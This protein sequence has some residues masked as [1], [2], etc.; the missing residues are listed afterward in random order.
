MLKKLLILFVFLGLGLGTWQVASAQTGGLREF[1]NSLTAQVFGTSNTSARAVNEA[2][3]VNSATLPQVQANSET[4]VLVPGFGNCPGGATM[5]AGTKGQTIYCDG[6]RWVAASNL[7]NDGVSVGLPRLAL[8]GNSPLCIDSFGRI[9]RGSTANGCAGNTQASVNVYTAISPSSP[10]ARIVSTSQTT[11]TPNVTLAVYRLKADASATVN[12]LNIKLDNCSGSFN[13]V[14]GYPSCGFLSNFRLT[15][16]SGT[17]YSG[18][19]DSLAT[20]VTFTN[21]SLG[22]T[23]NQWRD[24]TLVA[25]VVAL[26]P[27]LTATA[28]PTLRGS[29]ITGVDSNFRSLN[30]SQ[31]MDVTAGMV[32]FQSSGGSLGISSASAS[33]GTCNPI[34]VNGPNVMCQVAFNYTLV[35]Q[36]NSVVYVSKSPTTGL[37]TSATPTGNASLISILNASNPADDSSDTN[38]SFAIQAGTAR[39]FSAV[40]TIAQGTGGSGTYTLKITGI[41]FGSSSAANTSSTLTSGL[42][43]LQAT[44]SF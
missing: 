1:F 30:S 11:T 28:A 15:D 41:K 24:V 42:S 25:D 43:N 23:A 18:S 35:N 7:V 14:D 29:S 6:T 16:G 19:L 20:T 36:G 5:P 4:G 37:V 31:A 21:L 2:L 40:G 26:P 8:G 27:T 9:F 32:T 3:L 10:A 13:T 17:N 39:S 38:S 22:L 12:G 33:V 44:T 34:V